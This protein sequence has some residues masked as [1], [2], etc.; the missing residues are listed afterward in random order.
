MPP[1]EDDVP[2]R[3]DASAAVVALA[4]FGGYVFGRSCRRTGDDGS[5]G[6]GRAIPPLTALACDKHPDVAH[7]GRI[8]RGRF[9][10]LASGLRYRSAQRC[11]GVVGPKR[12]WRCRSITRSPVPR[13]Q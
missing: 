11:L 12:Q 3:R 1:S 10:S 4:R 9:G 2:L 7:F 5:S 6:T 13:I 8:D